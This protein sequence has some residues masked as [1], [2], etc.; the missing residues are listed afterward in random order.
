LGREQGCNKSAEARRCFE[1]AIRVFFD[2]LAV[3]EQDWIVDGEER[4]QT[5]GTVDT[6]KLVVVAHTATDEEDGE[7]FIRIISA[8]LAEKPERRRYERG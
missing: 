1:D 4:W 5:V 2:P 6:Y 3:R 7:E 8:R